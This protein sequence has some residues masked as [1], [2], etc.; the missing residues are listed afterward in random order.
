MNLFDLICVGLLVLFT[1]GF[2]LLKVSR[3]IAPKDEEE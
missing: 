2:V 3:S 1:G